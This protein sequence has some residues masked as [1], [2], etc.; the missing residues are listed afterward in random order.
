MR[1]QSLFIRAVTAVALAWTLA[2]H[3]ASAPAAPP[4]NVNLSRLSP[5]FT[6]GVPMMA[7]D[8]T[9]P[10]TIVVIWRAFSLPLWEPNSGGE[11]PTAN[12][13]LSVSHDGGSTFAKQ[14]LALTTDALPGCN[15]PFVVAGSDGA[16]HA[17]ASVFSWGPPVKGGTWPGH[18]AIVTSTDGGKSFGPPTVAVGTETVE[19]FDAGIMPIV[20]ATP[21]PWDG[22]RAAIDATTGTLFV[23]GSRAIP[24]GRPEHAQRYITASHDGGETFGRIHAIDFSDWPERWDGDF[25]S[26]YGTLAVAYVA[27][28]TPDAGV[29]CPCAIFE[30]S[31]DEGKTF[32][33][34]LVA[35]AAA[36]STAELVH[37]PQ[38]AADRAHAG[39]FAFTLVAADRSAVKVMIT[40]DGGATWRT[41]PVPQPAGI[42]LVCGQGGSIFAKRLA[43]RRVAR[44]AIAQELRS[45]CCHDRRHRRGQ[46]R[47]DQQCDLDLSRGNCR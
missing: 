47:S 22:G 9:D 28:S 24:P 2:A 20:P 15:A 4:P 12:C 1:N 39:R 25:V 41:V 40:N 11:R 16:I 14:R 5:R 6:A 10:K 34:H 32:S 18:A 36:F 33:R 30:T 7:I 38:L 31:I 43:C 45:L 46:A 8:P 17:G 21:T 35:R 26:S 19:R 3:S 13:F 23:S 27:A 44:H 29:Q 37:Y 42:R